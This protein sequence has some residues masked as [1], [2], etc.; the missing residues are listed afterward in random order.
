MILQGH[1]VFYISEKTGCGNGRIIKERRL[2]FEKGYPV[3][4]NLTKNYSKKAV[5][6]NQVV[7]F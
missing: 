5:N 3:K 7:M 6:L 4:I 1:P 2:L